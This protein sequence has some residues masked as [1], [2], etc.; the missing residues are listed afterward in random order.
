MDV[1]QGKGKASLLGGPL[2]GSLH[3]ARSGGQHPLLLLPWRK[4]LLP[5]PRP[6]L[7]RLTHSSNLGVG[8]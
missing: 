7:G 8:I 3:R 2:P 4:P 6:S 1:F 5:T